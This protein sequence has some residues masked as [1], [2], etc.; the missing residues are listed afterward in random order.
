METRGRRK[1]SIAMSDIG[2]ATTR[3]IA[4]STH[5]HIRTRTWLGLA[6]LGCDV[7]RLLV[8]FV[9]ACVSACECTVARIL[10]N[11]KQ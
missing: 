4:M 7:I 10:C 2:T 1:F 8:C 5:H 11:V 9:F 3:L 6:W